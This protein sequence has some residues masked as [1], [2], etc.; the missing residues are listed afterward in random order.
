MFKCFNVNSTAALRSVPL[1]ICL[2]S[3]MTFSPSVCESSL[4]RFKQPII[5][6]YDQY[7]GPGELSVKTVPE[8]TAV[9]S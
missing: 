2:I 4:R 9:F 6:E 3:C 8:T 1:F 7:D 5:V